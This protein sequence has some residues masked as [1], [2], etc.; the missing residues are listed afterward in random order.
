MLGNHILN[1]NQMISLGLI[2]NTQRYFSKKNIGPAVSVFF[3]VSYRYYIVR[4]NTGIVFC[5]HRALRLVGVARRAQLRA[6]S[7]EF[8]TEKNLKIFGATK[9][10][11]R[12]RE[13]LRRSQRGWTTPG[14]G[15]MSAG[16]CKV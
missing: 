15:G 6:F 16:P 9:I 2:R 8:R 10:F 12:D 7:D 3:E 1:K 5:T 14:L 11:V 13:S 4:Y